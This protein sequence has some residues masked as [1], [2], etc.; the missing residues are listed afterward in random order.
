[1]IPSVCANVN[2]NT[3]LRCA[4]NVLKHFLLVKNA[5]FPKPSEVPMSVLRE[6]DILIAI[7]KPIH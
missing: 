4:P 7:H 1:M 5:S 3:W 2:E 6:L